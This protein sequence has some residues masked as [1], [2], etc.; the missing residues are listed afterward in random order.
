VDGIPGRIQSPERLEQLIGPVLDQKQDLWATQAFPEL[1]RLRDYH[2]FLEFAR[3][4]DCIVDVCAANPW[5]AAHLGREDVR[6]FEYELFVV[7]RLAPPHRGLIAADPG[8]PRLM[9]ALAQYV[10]AL[11][12]AAY[13][14]RLRSNGLIVAGKEDGFVVQ[15]ASGRRF[16]EPYRLHALFRRGTD[17]SPWQGLEGER[18]RGALNRLLGLELVKGGPH[19]DWAFRGDA[20]VAGPSAGPRPPVVRFTPDGHI[21]NIVRLEGMAA[22]EGYRTRWEQIFPGEAVRP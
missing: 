22:S 15:D 20:A 10:P 14:A 19:V 18:L 9:A 6:C 13:V 12:Y 7:S 11:S 3:Q 5:A 4:S 2:S 21:G 17:D 1:M 8:D 16:H